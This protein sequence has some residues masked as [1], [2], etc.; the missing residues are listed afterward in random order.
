M[1]QLTL[2]GKGLLTVSGRSYVHLL[3][4]TSERAWA[5][6]MTM[7]NTHASDEKGITGRARSHIISRLHK[8][9]QTAEKLVTALADKAASG[10]STRDTLEAKAYVALLQGS[11]YFEKRTWDACVQNYSIAR[12]LYNVLS[13]VG[14]GDVFKDLLSD[15]IDPSIRYA[16]YQLKT[17]RTVPVQEIAQKSFPRA[18]KS[19]VKDL[20]EIAPQALN[21]NERGS[22]TVDQSGESAPKIITWRSR[23]VKLEDAEIMEAWGRVLR[24]KS[25]LEENFAKSTD[26]ETREAAAAYD[27]VLTATQDAVDATKQAID[28]LKAE[29]VDNSDSRIQSLQVTR[30]AVNFEM[31]SWR[32]GRNRVLTGPHDG[33]VENYKQT[34]RG[35]KFK[36]SEEEAEKRNQEP[37]LPTSRK[38][39]K[40]KELAALHDGTLQN[41][42]TMKE[43]PGVA[44]DQGIATR[45]EAFEKYFESLR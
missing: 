45:I 5:H 31:V 2:S 10:A 6:A 26:K 38:L 17:P 42:R 11:K 16:S 4:L 18:D 14:K 25:Q 22:D 33:A 24:A 13:T 36:K 30:T 1:A 27:D 20:H 21:I 44:A 37:D 41:L 39:A 9:T 8:A 35:E 28:E 3:L 15:T 12:V 34:R 23:E 32:I 40:L 29:G 7:K 43:L 19:L